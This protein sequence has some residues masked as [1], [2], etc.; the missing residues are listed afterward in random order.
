MANLDAPVKRYL[1]GK[2]PSHSS[3]SGLARNFEGLDSNALLFVFSKAGYLS[4]EYKP[5]KKA[6]LD[7]LIDSCEG[8]ILW[9]LEVVEAKLSSLGMPV[10]RCFVNQEVRDDSSGEP[11]WVNL[12]TLSTY[13]NVTAN[14]VGKWLDSLDLRDNEGLGNQ[15]AMDLGL[16]TVAEMNAGG[17][18]TRKIAMWNLYPTQKILVDNGHP[19]DFDYEKN[20]KGAGKNSDVSVSSIDARVK[21]F[22]EEFLK[23]Y[24]DPATARNS[25]K[26]V[27]KTPRGILVRAEALL[28]KP[29]FFVKGI[30]RNRFK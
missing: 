23:L 5:E 14:T 3:T 25:E 4:P 2:L 24:G 20:L 26:L 29:D 30:Y 19:L 15:N 17:K 6:L 16:C 18:K 11:R 7:G 28:K 9:N 13:F 8:K 10:K 21:E 22:V 27:R 1:M 12:K